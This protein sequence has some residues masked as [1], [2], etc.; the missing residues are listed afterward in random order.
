MSQKTIVVLMVGLLGLVSLTG[1]GPKCTETLSKKTPDAMARDDVERV[2]AYVEARK[3]AIATA[4]EGSSLDIEKAKFTVTA[5]ELAI[6]IQ[7]Q[8]INLAKEG[9]DVY[10]ESLKQINDARCFLDE[11]L[12]KKGTVVGL[13]IGKG[14][15]IKKG[16]GQEI[17]DL[18]ASFE[19]QF[20]KEGRPRSRELEDAYNNGLKPPKVKKKG[21]KDDDDDDEDVGGPDESG[22][23]VS[24][25]GDEGLDDDLG[26]EGEDEGEGE[27][28]GA[29]AMDD[30]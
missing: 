27:G 30:F 11:V 24:G 3:A 14:V 15:Y 6:Q 22:D 10:D 12:D 5:C 13:K 19:E 16:K 17:R 29:G 23:D 28:E 1:C 8:I 2:N 21:E 4:K 9:G 26:D 25:G 18:Q 7:M 20:G